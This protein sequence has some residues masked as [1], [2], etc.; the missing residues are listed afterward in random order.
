MSR[1]VWHRFLSLLYNRGLYKA[2]DINILIIPYLRKK[3]GFVA[4]STKHL[5]WF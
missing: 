3:V 2:K 1:G 4:L 5:N